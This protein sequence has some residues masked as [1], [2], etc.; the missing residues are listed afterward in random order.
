VKAAVEASSRIRTARRFMW[1]EEILHRGRHIR[2]RKAAV[3]LCLTAYPDT[4]VEL[5]GSL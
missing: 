5:F 1:I 2:A 3:T 4:N